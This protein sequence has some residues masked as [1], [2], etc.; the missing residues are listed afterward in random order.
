MLGLR[1][2]TVDLT[3]HDTRWAAAFVEEAA[4]LEGAVGGWACRIEHIGSTAVP[5]LLAKP[6]L[7]IA[8]GIPVG[9]AVAPVVEA[10]AAVGYE[11]RGDA[12]DQGGHLLV[13]ESAPQVRTHHVHVVD[14]DGAQ[15]TAYLAFRTLLRTSPEA[16]AKYERSKRDLAAAH[17]DDRRRY[18]AGKVDVIQSLLSR[19]A[20]TD[21]LSPRNAE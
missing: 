7:D 18:T 1:Y 11:Y 21:Q 9:M 4:L 12:R 8:V 20:V 2:G 19:A 13:R 14:L 16:R 6:I 10:I 15:W 5:G 3:P 17:P